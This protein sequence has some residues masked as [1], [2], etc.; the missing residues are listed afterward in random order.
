MNIIPS[1]TEVLIFK[2]I[3]EWGPD[4]DDENYIIGTI[5]SSRTSDDLSYHGT[6]WYEQIYEVLGEDGKR[7]VG[8][9]GRGLIGNSFFMTKEDYI[10][11]LKYKISDNEKEILKLNEKNHIYVNKINEL[12]NRL[13]LDNP[14]KP[15]KVKQLSSLKY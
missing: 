4:Q 11:L 5:Q 9:Y 10:R 8:S 15:V 7:Y 1:G 13:E 3:R 12:E 6:S 14:S 2:Y